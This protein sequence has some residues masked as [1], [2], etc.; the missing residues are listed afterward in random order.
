MLVLLSSVGL[1]SQEITSSGSKSNLL[2]QEYLKTEVV[3]VLYEHARYCDKKLGVDSSG[4]YS[5]DL[6][7]V[8]IYQ[9]IV[10]NESD[11]HPSAG[12]WTHRYRVKDGKDMRTYNIAF[13]AGK[14]RPCALISLHMGT[15]CASPE[16]ENDVV[17]MLQS[18][19]YSKV[20]NI[21]NKSDF[22][23]TFIVSDVSPIGSPKQGHPWEEKWTVK[24]CNQAYAFKVHF[25]PDGQ[26]GTYFQVVDS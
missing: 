1:C 11:Q 9:P 10:M 3:E 18:S 8:R 5:V 26:G 6:G 12:V 7:E 22:F 23:N 19:F 21:C 17:T 15:S 14:N 2:F 16:L 25:Q 24:A 4:N 13:V 20:A